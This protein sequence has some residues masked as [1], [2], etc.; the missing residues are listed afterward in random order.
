MSCAASAAF[1]R[2]DPRK[3][4]NTQTSFHVVTGRLSS[5]RSASLP[6]RALTL[7]RG[8]LARRPTVT[9]RV[10]PPTRRVSTSLM[11]GPGPPPGRPPHFRGN[12]WVPAPRA[13]FC[14]TRAPA[15]SP[16]SHPSGCG[17]RGGSSA[18]RFKELPAR[19]RP[20]TSVFHSISSQTNNFHLTLLDRR[21]SR[22][23]TNQSYYFERW[24]T[25][26]VRR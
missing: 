25:R 15:S 19:R 3:L 17:A 1:A 18:A 24:I 5:A 9:A 13:P 10:G 4:E 20:Q 12:V 7:F 22:T 6:G 23:K 8:T 16:A 21:S 11:S 26:L 2:A 14:A